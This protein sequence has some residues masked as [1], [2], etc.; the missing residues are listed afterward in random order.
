[1]YQSSP[2][3]NFLDILIEPTSIAILGSIAL[4]ALLGASLPF[5]TQLEKEIKKADP[6]TVKVV[7]LTP[8][9][10]QRIPQAPPI[11]APQIAAPPPVVTNLAQLTHHP[12]LTDSD[13]ARK[14]QSQTIER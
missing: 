14:N 7:E 10:L 4:H 5:F 9:E 11:P 6:G 13:P 3:K 1:M 2:R 8:N 12:V